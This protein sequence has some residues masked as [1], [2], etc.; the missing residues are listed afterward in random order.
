MVDLAVELFGIRT[1]Q[2]ATRKQALILDFVCAFENKK[3]ALHDAKSKI[4][5]IGLRV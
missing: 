4:N 2:I 3:Q 5:L 1:A